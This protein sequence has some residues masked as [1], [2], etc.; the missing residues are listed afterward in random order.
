MLSII[1]SGQHADIQYHTVEKTSKINAIDQKVTIR[2]FQFVNS[3][4]MNKITLH[5]ILLYKQTK[6]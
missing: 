4:K 2:A 5:Q 6:I 1:I 3:I